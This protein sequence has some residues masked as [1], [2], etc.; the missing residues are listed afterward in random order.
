MSSSLRRGALAATALV[1]SI[2]S[3][4]ACGAGKDAQT[5]G[6]RP[7]NAAT[8][9]DNL[10][11]QNGVVITQP[12]EGA[13]G[14]AVVSATIFNDGR[15]DETLE[16]ITVPGPGVE[17]ELSPAGGSGP[18]TVPAGGSIVLGGE[19]NASAVIDEGLKAASDGDVLDVVFRFSETGDV[20]L[21]AFVVP[22][23]NYYKK[24]GPSSLP[25]APEESPEESPEQS[26][27]GSPTGTPTS[28]P[29]GT[30]AGAAGGEA[31][32][33]DASSASQ[34]AGH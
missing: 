28:T 7:D 20:T 4:A 34:D 11:I 31:T 2:A 23:E 22:A 21:R 6:I 33:S 3:L 18:L 29:T 32:P 1:F 14:P 24:F 9:V 5:L 27:T 15:E 30:A 13:E 26:P 8:A 10:K 17:A 12:T 25:S 16:S 19:G